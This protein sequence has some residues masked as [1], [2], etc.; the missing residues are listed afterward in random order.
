VTEKFQE[1][2]GMVKISLKKFFWS[3]AR[4]AVK[5]SRVFF[6]AKE[7]I[8]LRGFEFSSKKHK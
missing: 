8:F 5:S 4:Y 6:L 7:K 1:K 2:K 3:Y